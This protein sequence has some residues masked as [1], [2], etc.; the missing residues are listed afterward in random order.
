M[1]APL[2]A[3][4]SALGNK[5]SARSRKL[6]HERPPCSRLFLSRTE[7]QVSG[8]V[9]W[10][11]KTAE[12]WPTL[13]NTPSPSSCPGQDTPNC[14]MKMGIC[15]LKM[16]SQRRRA[17]DKRTE[18]RVAGGCLMYTMRTEVREDVKRLNDYHLSLWVLCGMRPGKDI[19]K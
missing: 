12:A 15:F 18:A 11:A 13:L 6:I 2:S 4:D 16:Y 19:R 10:S 14:T 3:Y 8:K 9:L 7:L 17:R 5:A 1:L